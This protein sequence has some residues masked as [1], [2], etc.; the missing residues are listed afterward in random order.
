[1]FLCR[2]LTFRKNPGKY[3]KVPILP[4]DT[5]SQNTRRRGATRGSHHQVARARLGHARGWC[6]RPSHRLDACFRLHIPSDLKTSWVRHFPQTE[7]RCATTTRNGD[8]EPET[9]FWHPAGMGIWRRSSPSSSPTSL[10]QPSM[11]PHPCV[12]NSRCRPKGVV[13]IG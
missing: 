13:G 8:S 5:R 2:N 6:G 10:H 12:S 3:R 9:S 4:E 1:L 7:F 11:I